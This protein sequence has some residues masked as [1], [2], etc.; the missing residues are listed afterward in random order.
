MP[1]SLAWVDGWIVMPFTDLGNTGGAVGLREIDG[2]GF[3][4]VEFDVPADVQ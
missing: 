1:R 4:Y 2:I 3:G